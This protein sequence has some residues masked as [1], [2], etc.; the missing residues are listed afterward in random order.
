M[1][2]ILYDVKTELKKVLDGLTGVDS[3]LDNRLLAYAYGWP[4]PI[5]EGYPCAYVLLGTGTKESRLSQASNQVDTYFMIRIVAD[6]D[7][8]EDSYDDMLK[9]ID[10]VSTEIRKSTHRTLG[11]KVNDLFVS[12][13]VNVYP[14]D[15]HAGKVVV[16]ELNVIARAL[17]AIN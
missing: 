14:S 4:K 8:T 6:A 15:D 9:A 12:P 7:F 1:S 10:A 17:V 2:T 13:I 3:E 5:P 16:G 11:G